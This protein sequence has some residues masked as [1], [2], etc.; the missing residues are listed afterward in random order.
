MTS[1]DLVIVAVYVVGCTVLGAWLGRS[2]ATQGL[3]GY[4][5]GA[6]AAPTWAIM[7]SIVATETSTV[8]FLSL[9]G[10]AYKEGGDL[11][12]LQ[13]TIGYILGRFLVAGVLL[14]A[15]FRGEIYSAY[16]V[17]GQ[18]FGG[19]VKTVASLMFLTMRSLG[20]GLRLALTSQVIHLLT[21]LDMTASILVMG[22]ATI[23]YTYLGGMT[24]VIWTD[25]IQFVVYILGG[26]L[27]LGILTQAVG[28]FEA[29]IL[30]EPEKFRVFHLNFA[31]S[32]PFNLWAGIGGGMVL[33]M[34]T[35]GTDQLMVQRYLAA[36]GPRQAAAALIT[37][38]FVVAGQFALFLVIGVALAAY[39]ASDPALAVTAPAKADA[40]FATFLTSPAMP[41]GV[42][43]VIVA[44]LIAAAMSTLS[45][46][47]TASSASTVSDLIL[48]CLHP[49]ARRS[50]TVLRLS[51]GLTVV[52]GLVQVGIGWACVDIRSQAIDNVLAIAS[53]GAG[54]ILG[55][56]LLGT[57]VVP[58]GPRAALIGLLT[59]AAVI[60]GAKFGLD[61][62]FPWF[63]PLGAG[64]VF[65]V[66]GLLAGPG[67][68]PPGSSSSPG[69]TA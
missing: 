6:R 51:M 37:S 47:L 12:Y 31:W 23:L 7:L 57:F 50:K 20:D 46:S 48:P 13:L 2:T 52:W 55:L 26:G 14:P 32:D 38:G 27:A 54:L 40:A 1:I 11:R 15:Y 64:T 44:A 63:A 68:S 41:T 4:F 53:L 42:R 33:S 9:P 3:Q 56:F 34:A 36:R 17:L 5:L 67:G 25:V 22:G 24:A 30:A 66:G 59:G 35:H 8:T 18:R 29:I 28:G 62:A 45:S 60:F 19:S 16:E 69:G 65:L 21:G 43:G 39:F 10:A 49:E 58:A 61:L